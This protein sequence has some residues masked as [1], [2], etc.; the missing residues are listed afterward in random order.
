MEDLAAQVG[1]PQ[2]GDAEAL[3]AREMTSVRADVRAMISAEVGPLR[4]TLTDSIDRGRSEVASLAERVETDSVVLA[5]VEAQTKELLQLQQ[6]VEEMAEPLADLGQV[7]ELVAAYQELAQRYTALDEP[8]KVEG[9]EDLRSDIAALR[10]RVDDEA[11]ETAALLGRQH[12]ELSRSVEQAI[13]DTLEAVA[14]PLRH[15]AKAHDQLNSRTERLTQWAERQQGQ[16]V[17]LQ[18]SI[19]AAA[20]RLDELEA[21]LGAAVQGLA[22]QES[23]RQPGT[24][25]PP[26]DLVKLLDEQLRAAGERLSQL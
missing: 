18:S 2:G 26:V 21:R 25:T 1:A 9:L 8:K 3:V 15:I 10:M 14:E 6:A 20:A 24:T 19:E 12:A 13:Q 23:R 11:A 17:G 4:M 22:Q 16:I 5:G 7:R